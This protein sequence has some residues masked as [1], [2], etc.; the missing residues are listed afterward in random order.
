[1]QCR[2]AARLC[3]RFPI[4]FGFGW[5]LSL[6]IFCSPMAFFRISTVCQLLNS[7]TSVLP[8]VSLHPLLF[9]VSYRIIP[10]VEVSSFASKS[11]DPSQGEGVHILAYFPAGGPGNHREF[12]QALLEIRT[13][14]FDRAKSM[15]EK[16]RALGKPIKLSRVMEIAGPGVAPGRPHVARALVEAGHVATEGDAFGLY[17]RDQGPAFARWVGYP[18]NC[19]LAIR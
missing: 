17:L 14:R 11:S 10:G 18:S 9:A 3:S 19:R 2:L 16:L 8:I 5:G 13:G 7:S 4:G 1:M 15:V 12:H 6:G